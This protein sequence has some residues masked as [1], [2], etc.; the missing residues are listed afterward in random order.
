ML[1]CKGI[2]LARLR[3]VPPKSSLAEHSLSRREICYRYSLGGRAGCAGVSR[4]RTEFFIRKQPRLE[5]ADGANIRCRIDLH[6]P[7]RWRKGSQYR[8][9]KSRGGS[10][11][12]CSGRLSQKPPATGSRD[13]CNGVVGY[14]IRTSVSYH[15]SDYERDST[16]RQFA[17]VGGRYRQ[18]Y[19]YAISSGG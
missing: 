12:R 13:V 5:L 19:C 15:L 4:P 11:A 3:D 2:G 17:S 6:H 8:R 7:S 14:T 10:Y 18:G 16:G 9:G 1:Q